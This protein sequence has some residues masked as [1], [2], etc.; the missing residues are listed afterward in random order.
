MVA[1]VMFHFHKWSDWV[2][3]ERGRI[4]HQWICGPEA[5]F[6]RY[7]IQERYCFKCGK[8]Q[9]ENQRTTLRNDTRL[10][11]EEKKTLPKH[12]KVH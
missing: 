6:G 10:I 1:L 12:D 3:T 11:A 9:I 4:V 2:V 7:M 5:V 8:T